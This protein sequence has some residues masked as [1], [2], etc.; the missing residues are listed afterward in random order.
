MFVTW[1]G[2]RNSHFDCLFLNYHCSQTTPYSQLFNFI[3]YPNNGVTSFSI[4][5]GEKKSF[6]C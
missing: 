5:K 1:E 4:F 6:C 2:V 3:F